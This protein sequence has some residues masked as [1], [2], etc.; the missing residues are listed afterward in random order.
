M[1]EEKKCDRSLC[2]TYIPSLGKEVECYVNTFVG[3]REFDGKKNTSH[4]QREPDQ[5][6]E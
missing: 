3:A 2:I 1:I 4:E 5:L 6:G